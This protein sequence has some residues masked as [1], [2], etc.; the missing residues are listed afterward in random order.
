MGQTHTL[1]CLN[2]RGQRAC[3]CECGNGRGPG[4]A[5]GGEPGQPWDDL[6]LPNEINEPQGLV[7][8]GCW[9]AH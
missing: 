4:G 9:G 3:M 5:L 2:Q 1:P 7:C 8:S 6:P